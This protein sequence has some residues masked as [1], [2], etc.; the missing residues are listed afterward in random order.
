M[1]LDEAIGRAMRGESDGSD[2]I[3][4]MVA[5]TLVLPSGAEVGERFEGFEPVLFDRDGTT[6]LGVFTS[7]ELAA[8][9]AEIAPYAVTLT[10]RELLRMM[11]A[12]HGLAVNPGHLAGFELPPSGVA[13]LRASLGR[14]D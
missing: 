1:A 5:A 8:S 11:P 10:G 6:V 7:L 12:D 3:G 13:G 9:V 14:E 4:L 2:V